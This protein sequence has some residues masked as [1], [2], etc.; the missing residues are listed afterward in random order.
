[1]KKKTA[2]KMASAKKVKVVDSAALYQVLVQ[3]HDNVHF[4]THA[5]TFEVDGE[6]V[7]YHL[8]QPGDEPALKIKGKWYVVRIRDLAKSILKKIGGE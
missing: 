5:Q 2:K 1:M 8:R 4:K 7:E 6:P 3:Q